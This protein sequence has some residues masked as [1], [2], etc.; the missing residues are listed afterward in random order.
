MAC[1]D[2]GVCG[3]TPAHLPAVRDCCLR[4]ISALKSYR[5]ADNKTTCA[6]CLGWISANCIKMIDCYCV[7]CS[8]WIRKGA[9]SAGRT[10]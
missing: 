1:Y 7:N 6:L 10:G 5:T 4:N 8:D 2:G 9:V 3:S